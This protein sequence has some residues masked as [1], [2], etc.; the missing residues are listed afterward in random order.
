M[1]RLIG[2]CREADRAYAREVQDPDG[3]GAQQQ[4]ADRLKVGPARPSLF[5]KVPVRWRSRA[6]AALAFLLGVAACGAVVWW[7][8]RPSPTPVRADEHAVEL[9]LFEAVPPRTDPGESAPSPLQVYG[10]L[11]LSGRVTSTVVEVGALTRSLQ[12]RVPELPVTVSPTRR[13]HA[14]NLTIIVRD[15]KAATRWAPGDRP[16]TVRWRDRYGE[17]HLDKAGDF[18][19]SMAESLLR[20]IAAVCETSADR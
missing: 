17:M 8:A 18:D 14:V 20:H 10:A 2:V 13:F 1:P 3:G 19:R 7:Q 4:P 11:L 12:V 15:C 5:E 6:G 16:F 9:V